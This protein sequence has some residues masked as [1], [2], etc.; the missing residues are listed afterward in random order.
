MVGEGRRLGGRTCCYRVFSGRDVGEWGLGPLGRR[1]LF[2]IFICCSSMLLS[3]GRI[4][5]VGSVVS[6]LSRA[7]GKVEL[8]VG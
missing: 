5:E 2:S 8:S 6:S 4:S 3:P 7:R 1:V